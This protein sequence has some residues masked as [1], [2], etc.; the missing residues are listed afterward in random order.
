MNSDRETAGRT[1]WL[2]P[3]TVP[4]SV[5]DAWPEPRLKLVPATPTV[6]LFRLVPADRADDE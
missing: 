2:P 3:E 1:R 4:H 6:G 5:A